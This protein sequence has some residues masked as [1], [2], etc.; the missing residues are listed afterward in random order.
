MITSAQ[1]FHHPETFRTQSGES[2]P[3]FTLAYESYG[4]L[5]A[6]ASNV[7]LLFHALSG[8]AHAA[9][10]CEAVP[11]V[12]D[13]WTEDVRDGWWNDFIGPGR[14]LDTQKYCVICA[15]YLGGCYG[16]T[17]PSSINPATGQPWG[18]QFP[19]LSVND[20]VRSQVLLLDSLGI[21]KLHAVIG[22]SIGGLKV[23]FFKIIC[24]KSIH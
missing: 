21:K 4:E 7:I 17:G 8:T 5:N 2:L 19:H 23:C 1:F 14:P 12:G 16:S 20:V 3:G 18:S 9:G 13:R 24:F 10:R 22:P 15:N 6:D 11:G